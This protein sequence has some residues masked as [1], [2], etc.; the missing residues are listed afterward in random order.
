M[1]PTSPLLTAKTCRRKCPTWRSG[2]TLPFRYASR[3]SD[4]VIVSSA[5]TPF[6]QI[7]YSPLAKYYYGVMAAVNVGEIVATILSPKRSTHDEWFILLEIIIVIL[8][9]A[10]VT[11]PLM[12]IARF[13]TALASLCASPLSPPAH[14]ARQRSAKSPCRALQCRCTPHHFAGT[15]PPGGCEGGRG[16]VQVFFE[17]G[18]HI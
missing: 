17:Q 18:E 2:R 8:L 14:Q 13:I 4:P 11:H 7:L 10:E 6:C 15:L 16:A 9:V 12:T 3:R 5:E 1:P